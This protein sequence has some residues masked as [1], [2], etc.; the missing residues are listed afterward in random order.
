MGNTAVKHSVPTYLDSNYGL[1]SY[2]SYTKEI[3]VNTLKRKK[4]YA[5]GEFLAKQKYGIP[6][7]SINTLEYFLKISK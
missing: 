1:S 6:R 4:Y 2:V 5:G 7:A 3:T